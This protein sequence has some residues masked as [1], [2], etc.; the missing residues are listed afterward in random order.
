VNGCAV[1]L[2]TKTVWLFVEK[3]DQKVILIGAKFLHTHGSFMLSCAA[4]M[5]GLAPVTNALRE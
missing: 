4:Y 3:I 5:A 2:R 1:F